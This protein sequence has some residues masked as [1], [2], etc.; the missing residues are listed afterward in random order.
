MEQFLNDVLGFLQAGFNQVNAV[1]GLI[2]AL[3]AAFMMT[4]YN[5]ILT[6]VA[7]ATVVHVLADV[8]LPVVAASAAFRLPPLL[9]PT[10]WRYVAVLF[11]GYLIIVTVFFIARRTLLRR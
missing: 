6:Y 1:Q 10:Y 3:V 11:V 7:G 2:I 9:E 4:R 5:Q 8:L